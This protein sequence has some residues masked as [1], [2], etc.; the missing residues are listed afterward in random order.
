[1]EF[2]PLLMKA[3]ILLDKWKMLPPVKRLNR[4]FEW[5]LC[6]WLSFLEILAVGQLSRGIFLMFVF[7]YG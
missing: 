1:M 4:D 7:S 6:L 5:T 3:Y 2:F